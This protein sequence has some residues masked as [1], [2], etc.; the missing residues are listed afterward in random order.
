LC[1]NTKPSSHGIFGHKKA[2]KYF[3][4]IEISIAP[5]GAQS[6]DVEASGLFCAFCGQSSDIFSPALLRCRFVKRV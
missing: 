4:S 2:Q 6:G 5:L 3:G 1:P